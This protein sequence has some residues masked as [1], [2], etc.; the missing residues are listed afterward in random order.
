[1]PAAGDCN[2]YDGADKVD[3][4]ETLQRGIH[5]H[6]IDEEGFPKS[7][8]FPV[9]DLK[10][11]ARKG[12]SVHR[13]SPDDDTKTA[14]PLGRWSEH[15]DAKAGAVRAI[16][17]AEGRQAFDVDAAPTAEDPAHALVRFAETAHPPA[18]PRFERDKLLDVFH[19]PDFDAG[20]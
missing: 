12:V 4:G 11:P 2:P 19:H 9:K 18:S 20:R 16:L 1:M 6:W 14:R 7:E 13:R 5:A 17:S 15:V 8:A 3:D 10:D